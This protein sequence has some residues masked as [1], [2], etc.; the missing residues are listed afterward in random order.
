MDR[1]FDPFFTTKGMG[2]GTGLGLATAYGIIKCHGGIFRVLSKKG[3]GSSFAFYLPAKESKSNRKYFDR[4]KSAIINGKGNILLVDDEQGVID[5]CSEMIKSLGYSVRAV[6]SG[7]AAVDHIKKNG[8]NIDLV[9]L[10][11]IMPGMNGFETLKQIK[12]IS[13]NARVLISSGYSKREDL[14]QILDP[15]IE[16]FIPKPYDVAMLSEKIN[17]VFGS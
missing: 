16:N 1:I 14:L 13:P 3:E 6:T 7:G 10:D 5:V 17:L 11:M 9:I 2:G 12:T 15:E 4:D 8:K